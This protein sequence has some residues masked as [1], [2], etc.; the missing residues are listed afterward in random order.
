MKKLLYSLL[1][2]FIPAT[3]VAQETPRQLYDRGIM[4][5][6]EGRC[7]EAKELL[8]KASNID[9]NNMAILISLSFANDCAKGQ[10]SNEVGK[11]LFT[12]VSAGNSGNWDNSLSLAK[13]ATNLAPRYSPAYVHLG[14][15]YIQMLQVGKGEHYGNDAINAYRK[16]L[17]IDTNNGLAHYNLGVAYAAKGEW[18]LAKKHLSSAGVNVPRDLILEIGKRAGR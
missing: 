13:R 14:V 8:Q 16:A 4:L 6:K 10:I 18:K 5:G 3:L 15:V 2:M 17:D 11:N 1:L 7:I 12:S 9:P